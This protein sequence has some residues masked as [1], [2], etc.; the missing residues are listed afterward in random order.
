MHF[1]LGGCWPVSHNELTALNGNAAGFKDDVAMSVTA[2][3]PA[4]VPE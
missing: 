2:V 1:I 4:V 3:V